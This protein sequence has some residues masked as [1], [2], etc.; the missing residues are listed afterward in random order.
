MR[1]SG[2]R[3]I[4]ACVAVAAVVSLLASA[5]ASAS[6]TLFA[7]SDGVTMSTSQ[8]AAWTAQVRE[9]C[10][11]KATPVKGM[12]LD[13]ALGDVARR[14]RRNAS[15]QALR[16]F[17]RSK[18]ARRATTAANGIF[19]GVAEGKPWAAIAAAL[20]VHELVP[21]D[22]GPLITLAGLVSA[23]GMPQQALAL[24][25]AAQK[26]KASAPGPMGI[27]FRAIADNNRGYALFLLGDAR[28]AQAYLRSAVNAAP[29]LAEARINLDAAQQCQW[30]M[31]PG[32]NRGDPPVIADPPFTRH[33]EPSEWTTD[34]QGNPITVTSDV[35]DL[36]DGTA[37]Q[38]ITIALPETV[39]QADA[40]YDY[41][42]NAQDQLHSA[43]DADDE[44]AQQL[45]AQVKAPNELTA[46]RQGALTEALAAAQWQ[47]DLR[48]LY[49]AVKTQIQTMDQ[50][51]AAG[52]ELDPHR[53]W[54]DTVAQFSQCDGAYDPLACEDQIDQTVCVPETNQ[55]F[56]QWISRMKELN[57]AD[58]RWEQAFWQYATGVAANSADP[59]FNQALQLSAEAEIMTPVGTSAGQTGFNRYGVVT[60]AEEW[61][62]QI[63]NDLCTS[64][65]PPP[66]AS[67]TLPDEQ[68][69][70]A[71]PATLSNWKAS[72]EI[73]DLFKMSVKCDEISFEAGTGWI[74]PFAN[75]TFNRN[76][77]M[78]VF[79]GVQAGA[80]GAGVQEG[81]F[82]VVGPGGNVVDGGLRI[83]ASA[84]AGVGPVSYERSATLN[85][86]VAGVVPFTEGL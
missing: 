81:A 82:V 20:R 75:L 68:Q 23:Q 71:C 25:A 9:N 33:N 86:A 67:D 32:G 38:P 7:L 29:E 4:F 6:T 31:L 44:Q 40:M 8:L 63:G 37:W 28:Q 76:G 85:I 14:L 56:S 74:G 49:M 30:V 80:G 77:Q 18:D 59:A 13:R 47:P 34:D 26:R 79:T 58:L 35:Y 50:A 51:T 2:W 70:P 21:R 45:E 52:G 65:P 83:S 39:E 12:A 84:S 42:S 53:P 19:A 3:A 72:V 48:P 46:A 62:R 60:E 10:P 57:D 27:S 22:A 15:A 17:E 64:P 41:Y 55:E 1:R 69:A 61:T 66:P 54:N 73:D 78:T 5:S 11:R 36:S 24:L 43:A 16:G